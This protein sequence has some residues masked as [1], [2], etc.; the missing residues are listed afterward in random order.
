MKLIV[1]TPSRLHFSLIDLNGSLGR[2]DG[3]IGVA[4]NYPNVVIEIEP[5]ENSHFEIS[6]RKNQS[7]IQELVEKIIQNFDIHHGFHLHVKEQ[8]PNH[9]GLGSKTQLCL[10]IAYA[11]SRMIQ[12]TPN[13]KEL[14][15]M[16]SRGGTSGIGVNIFQKGGFVLDAGHSYGNGLEK[17]SFLPSSASIAP[18]PPILFHSTL[19]EDWLFVNAIPYLGRDIHGKE[20]VNIFQTSCPISDEEVGKVCRIILMRILPGIKTNS[21]ELFGRGLTELQNVGFK[22]LEVDLQPE[23]IKNLIRFNLENGAHGAGISS[24][25]CLTYGIVKGINEARKLKVKIQ[26]F[27][28]KK[29]GGKV[30]ISSVKNS[31]FEITQ[32]G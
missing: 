17:N 28:D 2:V 4:L 6:A 25:G 13:I 21:I 8:I 11:I 15:R 26:D 16:T 27:L 10:A 20:E 32:N 24:F 5:S 23:L 14:A 7:L 30:F 9:V 1:K 31:G 22:K 18:P 12:R 3:G 19:P 29:D